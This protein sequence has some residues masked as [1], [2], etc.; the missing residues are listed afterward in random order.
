MPKISGPG[1]WDI[2]QGLSSVII[3]ILDSGVDCAHP[4]LGAKCT[5]GWNFYNNNSDTSDVYGH[6]TK[7]AGS[8]T[9]L[10][11]NATGVASVA[12]QNLLMPIRV[13]DTQGYGY[14]S[15]I[16]KGLTWAVDNG[17]RVMNLSFGGVA[18][19]STIA[20]A[21]QYVVNHG[22]LVVAAAGNCG[23]FDST[24][25]NPYMISVSATDSSDNLASFSSTGN[26]VD[27][28]APGVS[29]YTTTKGG[30]YGGV[31]GTSFSS[32]II[33][34]VAALVMSANAALTPTGVE[35][36]LEAN[37]DDLGAAGYDTSFGFGR[38]NA[39]KA[40][41]AA[42]VVMCVPSLAIRVTFDKS[43][44]PQN[45]WVIITTFV[46]WIDG[47]T[48]KKVG[49]PGASVT[50]TIRK[51]TPDDGTSTVTL[52][53][54]ANGNAVYSLKVKQKDPIGTW[55]VQATARKNAITGIGTGNFKVQ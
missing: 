23:C 30:S 17:A 29:I 49:T 42:V 14:V 8:A 32:P 33:A 46:G 35:S 21:A 19:I 9:A 24:A 41:L 6:G 47:A 5:A 34:G 18:G 55:Q 44:Y 37:A 54:N 36:V 4:D 22:G 26:Y 13:T 15:A 12:W 25:E 7:V 45:S 48:G 10:S 27:L 52:T 28:S 2:S 53:T 40:V 3:A 50:L 31:S 38:V 39:Y 1:A 43:T 51:P 11:N 20:S 16:A